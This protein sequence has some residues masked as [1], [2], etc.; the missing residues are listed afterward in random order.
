[1]FG[2]VRFCFFL[3][4]Y[5]LGA[6]VNA[7]GV[8]IQ[9]HRLT[10][11]QFFPATQTPSGVLAGFALSHRNPQELGISYDARGVHQE[12]AEFH[13]QGELILPRTFHRPVPTAGRADTRRG[14]S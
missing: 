12:M 13:T 2:I 1:M 5:L 4:V 3:T 14:R 10:A 11:D 7:Q 8:I 9:S 6:L